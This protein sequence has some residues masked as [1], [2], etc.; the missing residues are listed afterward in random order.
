LKGEP[1]WMRVGLYSVQVGDRNGGEYFLM[2]KEKARG[3]ENRMKEYIRKDR[4]PEGERVVV[5]RKGKRNRLRVFGRK[6]LR[7]GKAGGMEG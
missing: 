6:N 3:S 2:W 4:T 7:R 1:G 5:V